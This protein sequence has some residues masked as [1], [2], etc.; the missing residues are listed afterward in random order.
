MESVTLGLAGLAFVAGMVSF[1]SPCIFPLVPAYLAQLTGSNIS[2]SS[3]QTQKRIILSRSFG[4]ILGFTV[5]FFIDGCCIDLYRT[6]I[7]NVFWVVGTTWRDLDCSVWA[8]N[9]WAHFNS[10]VVDG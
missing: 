4:F 8:P 9:V 10:S 3:V 7:S 1:F 2:G 6:S 5:I